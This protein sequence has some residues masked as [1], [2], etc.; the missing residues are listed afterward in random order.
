MSS[1]YVITSA[2]VWHGVPSQCLLCWHYV[3]SMSPV[4]VCCV[5]IISPIYVTTSA[6][7]CHYIPNVCHY[8]CC[9]DIM[10][11][12]Y[13]IMPAV[14]TLCSQSMSLCLLFWH[15]VLKHP[16]ALLTVFPSRCHY[17]CWVDIMSP[18]YVT[19][20]ATV[21]TLRPV[22]ILR[23]HV[24]CGVIMSDCMSVC[25]LCWEDQYVSCLC[26]TVWR[27]FLRPHIEIVCYSFHVLLLMNYFV[28]LL[29]SIFITL[30]R[31]ALFFTRLMYPCK[32]NCCD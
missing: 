24:F 26:Y 21:L 4:N 13:V 2:A 19:M 5:V 11:P 32:V 20:S 12:V 6:V 29:L 1:V 3:P 10:S 8:V 9:V 15:Y 16:S 23:R 17:V 7:F 27:V 28:R 25:L 22:L 31:H 14:L 30:W 18:V